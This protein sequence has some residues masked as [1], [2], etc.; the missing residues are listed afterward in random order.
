MEKLVKRAKAGEFLADLIAEEPQL[1]DALEKKGLTLTVLKLLRDASTDPT[2]VDALVKMSRA[3][4]DSLQFLVEKGFAEAAVAKVVLEKRGKVAESA[5]SDSTKTK[6]TSD[7]KP[8]PKKE[9]SDSKKEKASDE[10]PRTLPAPEKEPE[11]DVKER[12]ATEKLKKDFAWVKNVYKDYKGNPAA[13]ILVVVLICIVMYAIAQ[14]FG[15]EFLSGAWSMGSYVL[16]GQNLPLA[17][18]IGFGLFATA[19]LFRGNAVVRRI[20]LTLG[21][22][23]VLVFGVFYFTRSGKDTLENIQK[24]VTQGVTLP[25]QEPK[26]PDQN[27]VAQVPP[28]AK[29]EFNPPAMLLPT[30]VPADAVNNWKEGSKLWK[31]DWT[32]VSPEVLTAI[33]DD[34]EAGVAA[35]YVWVANKVDPDYKY[36]GL[37]R[38]IVFE[39]IRVEFTPDTRNMRDL[40][41]QITAPLNVK[42]KDDG[43]ASSDDGLFKK[44]IEKWKSPY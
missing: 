15:S 27:P 10:A 43:T 17:I 16:S 7:D 4:S 24:I 12:G 35:Y 39:K 25:D 34:S 32:Q 13:K 5:S 36:L 37:D 42:I 2:K 30:A 9:A 20:F 40:Q 23:F 1:Q 33:F 31:H 3:S 26:T 18:V 28:V 8:A 21:V 22:A 44:I 14:S 19:F 6:T 29:T 38:I 41:R 11:K